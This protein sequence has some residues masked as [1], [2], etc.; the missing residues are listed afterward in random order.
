MEYYDSLT[1]GRDEK[2][3]FY[4]GLL[5]QWLEYE[6]QTKLKRSL[7]DIA[8]GESWE[9]VVNTDV[10]LQDNW[11]ACGVHVCMNADL[12]ASDIPLK[13]AFTTADTEFF[14]RKIACDILRGRLAYDL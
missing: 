11:H 14:R 5:K 3:S 1:A 7:D 6:A 2:A 13:G 8:P 12:I 9:C 10:A 4:G